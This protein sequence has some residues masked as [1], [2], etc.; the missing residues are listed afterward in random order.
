MNPQMLTLLRESRGYSGAQLAKLANIP[1]PTLSKM[2][3][4]LAQVD[5]ERLARI[6]AALEYPVDAFSW[7]DPV[8]GFGSAA[9]YHRKQQTIPQTALRKI[10][11]QVNLTRMRL[12]RLLRSIVIEPQY[13]VPVLELDEFGTPADVARAMR[14]FWNIPMG[15]IANMMTV[16]EAAGVIIVRSNLESPKISAISLDRVGTYPSIIILNTTLP[17]DRE[18]FTLAHELGHLVMHSALTTNDDAEAQAD[19]FAAEF[20]MPANEI[21]SQLR[22]M[23]LERAAQL[24]TVWRVAMSA[25]FRRAKDLGVID[26]RRYRSLSVL[27]SQRGWRKAEPVE[28]AHDQPGALAGVLQVHLA[29]HG[30]SVD[31]LSKVVALQ[32]DEFWRSVRCGDSSRTPLQC[33][34]SSTG[35]LSGSR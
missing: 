30:Y 16:I 9:F 21:R 19:Q 25:L 23:S 28:I 17:A 11:A 31:D 33:L 2:E 34:L 35:E 22:A 13:E 24:K 4:G 26:E 27:M 18:R 15:P 32:P 3:N 29:E 10:Q 7:T 6:A 5:G 20:L 1:Q 14:A 8:Y 12:E